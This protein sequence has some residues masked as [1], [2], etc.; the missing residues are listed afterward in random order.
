MAT[1]LDFFGLFGGGLFGAGFTT[2]GSGFGGGFFLSSFC[3][4]TATERPTSITK[5]NSIFL[6]LLI[7]F[8]SLSV[9]LIF[10]REGKVGPV[11]PIGNHGAKS[12]I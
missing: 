6:K 10:G 12:D 4:E 7:F 11:I 5:V 9:N 8:P 1:E 2:G 3:A